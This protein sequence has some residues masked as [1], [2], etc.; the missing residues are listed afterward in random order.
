MISQNGDNRIY[1]RETE[2]ITVH[3]VHAVH[4]VH[5][6]PTDIPADRARQ[7]FGI[8]RVYASLAPPPACNYARAV[9][10]ELIELDR[11][12]REQ[13]GAGVQR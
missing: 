8:Y 11:S 10:A 13:V 6:L 9:L 4:A 12:R 1:R 5:V 2:R 3:A 7:L